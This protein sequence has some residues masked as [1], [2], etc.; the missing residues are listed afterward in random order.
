MTH[1][2]KT[3]IGM[4][5]A[6]IEGC[7]VPI[8]VEYTAIQGCRQT[9]EDPGEEGHIEIES[10]HLDLPD[11]KRE[12]ELTEEQDERIMREIERDLDAIYD[13]YDD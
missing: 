10:C 4:T 6:G 7:D 12:L 11:D 3:T 2:Y 5:V 13:D 8:V 1:S 9:R